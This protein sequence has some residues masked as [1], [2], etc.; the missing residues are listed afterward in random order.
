MAKTITVK[1]AKG[2]EVQLTTEQVLALAKDLNLVE[3]PAVETVEMAK[4]TELATKVAAQDA[5]VLELT[6]KNAALELDVKTR[7]AA[8]K[9]ETIIRAGKAAPV[10]RDELLEFALASP[11]LF[12]KVLA[13]RPAFIKYDSRVGSTEDTGTLSASDEV[14]ALSKVE[15]EKNTKLDSA[16]AMG[17][18]FK[19]NPALYERYKT[20]A[21]IKV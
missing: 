15:Q 9:V 4:F 2:V 19:K 8:E 20:E 18:V 6:A 12:D 17:E 5:T 3:K 16:S 14:I 11:A 21:A 13:K 10:E 1:D 7:T